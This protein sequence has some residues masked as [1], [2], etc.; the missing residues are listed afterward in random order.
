MAH[1]SAMTHYQN[2]V[3]V[4]SEIVNLVPIVVPTVVPSFVVYCRWPS[5][6]LYRP[7][8]NSTMVP[9]AEWADCFDADEQNKINKN[10]LAWN[11]ICCD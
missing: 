7:K 9:A 3:L 5:V 11:V 2:A 10:Q 4:P 1:C 8:S 6:A